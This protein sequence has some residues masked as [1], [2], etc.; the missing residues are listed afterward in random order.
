MFILLLS[1]QPDIL[2]FIS[3]QPPSGQHP[4][5][6]LK[7]ISPNHRGFALRAAPFFNFLPRVIEALFFDRSRRDAASPTGAALLAFRRLRPPF[8][9]QRIMPVGS[10]QFLEYV[11]TLT[12]R[13]TGRSLNAVRAPSSHAATPRSRSFTTVTRQPNFFACLRQDSWLCAAPF[14]CYP[15]LHVSCTQTCALPPNIGPDITT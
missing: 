7:R 14:C 6:S 13:D 15:V 4:F 3:L 9:H 5:A 2:I 8:S 1:F 12:A 10:P 11:I